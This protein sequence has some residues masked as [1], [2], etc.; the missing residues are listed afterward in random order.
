M[1]QAGLLYHFSSKQALLSAVL[2]RRDA[3]DVNRFASADDDPCGRLLAVVA[4]V[5]SN[6]SQPGLVE[7][8]C[9]ISAEAASADHPA[10]AYFLHRYESFRSM[11]RSA[12]DRLALRPGLTSDSAAIATIAVLD[13]LQIQWLL[14]PSVVDMPRVLLNYL[15][16]IVVSPAWRRRRSAPAS[17]SGSRS[18]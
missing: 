9:T 16:A 13:G 12:F 18:V 3:I 7:L 1:S 15:D 11:L 6:V 8:F 10:H 14:A 4:A 2:E 5:E 17:T